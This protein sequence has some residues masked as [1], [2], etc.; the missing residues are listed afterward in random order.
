MWR[1][2]LFLSG[3]M[4]ERMAV[5]RGVQ[6]ERLIWLARELGLVDHYRKL[7]GARRRFRRARAAERIGYFGGEPEVEPLGSL[8][9][10]KDGT[11]RAVAARSLSR[12]GGEEA[13]HILARRLDD[14]S[15]LTRLRVA[16]NL[17]RLGEVAVT[18]LVEQ[19]GASMDFPGTGMTGAVTSTRVLGNL[20]VGEARGTLRRA[21]KEGGTTDLRAQA[22]LA[23][24]KVGDPEDLDVL[25]RATRDGSWPVRAQAAN[26]LGM[27]G[28]TTAIPD[29]S[30]LAADGAWWVRLNTCRALAGMGP[31]GE[32]A[33][34]GLLRSQDRYARERAA[35]AL[36]E[37][38][39]T[40]RMA[41]RLADEGER[42][43]RARQTV[44]ALVSAGITHNL[45]SLASSMQEGEAR[46]KL[47]AMIYGVRV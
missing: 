32:E 1:C 37:G 33:L 14:T 6:R 20:R 9:S 18:A 2:D 5:L 29:L 19:V 24:G 39:I 10:D 26:A 25:L 46:E 7:L 30:R 27:I 34:V 28:D 4:V 41:H 11:V 15:E 22:A 16:E 12:I 36:E 21:A 3:M 23:L 35:A 17:E 45:E 8:L 44:E 38:G 43:R 31:R 47:E 42:G 40:G 13:A